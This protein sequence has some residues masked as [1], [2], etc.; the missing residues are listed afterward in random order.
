MKEDNLKALI[1]EEIKSTLSEIAKRP[2]SKEDFKL[3]FKAAKPYV[4]RLY[5]MLD[6]ALDEETEP[7]I[8]E[9]SH[10]WGLNVETNEGGKFLMEVLFDRIGYTKKR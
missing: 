1:K 5:D 10:H 7:F 9:L 6:K 8:D 3:L 2:E 4:D